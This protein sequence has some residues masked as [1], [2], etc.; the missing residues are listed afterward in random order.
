MRPA[1]PLA[2]RLSP[3]VGR[4]LDRAWQGAC[5]AGGGTSWEARRR[6]DVCTA[7]EPSKLTLRP[8][9]EGLLPH[10]QP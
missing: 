7:H 9:E 1:V 2:P 10:I 6:A 5:A 8:E 4:A 3:G